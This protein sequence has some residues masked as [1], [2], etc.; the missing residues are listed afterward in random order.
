[1]YVSGKNNLSQENEE[2]VSRQVTI[3]SGQFENRMMRKFK[4]I[5]GRARRRWAMTT[6]THEGF[7]Q[8][9]EKALPEGDGQD[10]GQGE[11]RAVVKVDEVRVDLETGR[12]TLRIAK[13]GVEHQ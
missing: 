12:V 7:F 11:P 6:K 13:D 4:D 1:V 3:F 2:V 9:G 8:P 10:T 5:F